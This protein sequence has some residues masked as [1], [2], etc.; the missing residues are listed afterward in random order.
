MQKVKCP[1]C[2]ASF[3]A[4]TS[5]KHEALGKLKCAWCAHEFDDP[6]ETL[7]DDDNEMKKV[8]APA[9]TLVYIV[10]ARP[11]KAHHEHGDRYLNPNERSRWAKTL[12]KAMTWD[13]QEDALAAL[14]EANVTVVGWKIPMAYKARIL[15]SGKLSLIGEAS[16]ESA[17]HVGIMVQFQVVRSI[18]RETDEELL[19]RFRAAII[20]T[21]IRTQL[22]DALDATVWEDSVELA[23]IPLITTG[24]PVR[25]TEPA[26]LSDGGAIHPPDE[27]SGT[28][29]RVDKD[30]NCEEVREV[31]DA[32]WSEWADLFDKTES[33]F[34]GDDSETG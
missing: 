14:R 25:P 22:A 7:E 24:T 1:E 28:I 31:G 27:D 29:R 32:D 12:A 16:T 21:G 2:G 18:I 17:H 9:G 4:D 15:E 23:E 8:D 33:D 5:R 11:E 34:M 13:T 30:G 26:E 19:E 10:R 3:S 6:G 20:T